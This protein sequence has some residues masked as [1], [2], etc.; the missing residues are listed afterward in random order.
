[1]E[2]A[3][4]KIHASV[5]IIAQNAEKT[6][7][8]CLDSL[9]P[10]HEIILVDGGSSDK[11]E[12]IAKEYSNVKFIFNPWPGFIE[13]RNIS[14]DYANCDW[15]YMLDADEANTPEL[16][17]EIRKIV[18]ENDLSVVMWR[19]VRTEYFEGTPI[20][21]GHGKSQYQ[22]RLFQK[23]R[24]RYAGGNHHTHTIDGK[25]I[26]DQKNLVRDLAFSVRVLHDP[27]YKLEEMIAKLLRFSICVGTE[28]FNKGRRVSPLGIIFSFVWTSLRMIY[29]SRKMGS[30]G[31]VLA[32]MKAFGDG[33]GKLYI[34]N[35][36]HHRQTEGSRSTQKYL[37]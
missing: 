12:E 28:K 5:L 29:R 2:P 34:Y 24:V 21:E 20:E 4:E 15:C 22:E 17:E 6:L 19:V 1:M 18:L 26:S 8:R 3:A 32:L 23:K 16:N 30:R 13:Q 27:S 25:L 14:I 37:G 11:T 36:E 35:L 31:I 7:R 10:F 9:T 33:L